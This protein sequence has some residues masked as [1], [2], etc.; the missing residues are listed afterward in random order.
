MDKKS[1]GKKIKNLR[2]LH[3]LTQETLAE[4][5]DMDMRQVAR[6]EAGGSFPS[7]PSIL[8]LCEVFKITPNDLLDFQNNQNT[9]TFQLKS[10]I[11]DILSLAKEE[12]LVLIKKLI[13]AVL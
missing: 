6:I 7:L 11:N 3:S 4:F 10:D 13:L 12:Q 5:I 1:F 8:K 2:A 9:S